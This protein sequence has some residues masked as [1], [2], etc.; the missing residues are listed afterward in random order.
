MNSNNNWLAW[1]MN[2]VA[3]IFTALQP[4]ELLQIICMAMT[5]V[6]VVISSAFSIYKWY[7][8]ALADNKITEEEIEELAT[9]ISGRIAEA[10]STLGSIEKGE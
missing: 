8:K 10:K 2:G 5:I 3:G 7:K 1:V 6:S 9:I 4:T